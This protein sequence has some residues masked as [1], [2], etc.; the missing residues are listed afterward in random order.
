MS[1]S[2]IADGLCLYCE[3]NSRRAGDLYCCDGCQALSGLLEARPPHSSSHSDDPVLIRDFGRDQGESVLFECHVDPLACE[4][5][6]QGLVRLQNQIPEIRDLRWKRQNS[7]LSFEFAKGSEFPSRIFDLLQSMKLSPRWKK[8]NSPDGKEQNQLRSRWL[9]IGLTGAL[10]GNIMLLSFAIYAGLDGI[11]K[12]AFEWLQFVLFVPVFFWAAVPIYRTA[13]M[14]WRLR[15]LS[16]DLPLAVAFVSGSVLSTVSLLQGGDSLYYDSL[17]GFLFLILASRALLEGTLA[18]YLESPGLE[19][20]FDR[21]VFSVHRGQ[22][23]LRMSW[24]DLQVGDE[25]EL[26]SGDRIPVDG[27]LQ[28]PFAEIETAWMTGEKIPHLRLRGSEIEAGTRLL[29]KRALIEVTRLPQETQFAK[30]LQ[31]LSDRGE[32]IGTSLEGKIG[33]ALVVGCFLLIAL[34]FLVAPGLGF[35]ELFRRSIALLIVACPCAVSFAAP[36]ARAKANQIALK[37]GFWIRDPLVWWRLGRIRRLAFDKTGTLTGGLFVMAP[38]SPMIDAHWKRVILSLENISRHPIAE[39]LRREWGAMELFPVTDAREIPG[40]GVE[41]QI[42]GK[43]YR[44]KGEQDPERLLRVSLEQNGESVV[45]VLLQDEV[46]PSVEKTLGRFHKKFELFVISGDRKNRVQEFGRRYGFRSENLFSELSPEGKARA[47]DQ[48]Q[49]DLYFGDGTN[50]LPALKKAPVSVAVGAA[51]PEAQAAAD[52]LMVDAGFERCEELFEIAK[53]TRFIHRRN[54]TL[55]LVYNFAA[56]AAALFGVIHPLG[57]ALLMPLA[58]LGLLASTLRGT[59]ALRHL[60]KR[61]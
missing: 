34:L 18:S 14:S 1:T 16:V 33:S 29:S 5:C 60:G 46:V 47:L 53:E 6:L 32:K 11:L 30:L 49:P 26:E 15:Q 27:I 35:D 17:A 10:A 61:K 25:V 13:W 3:V 50:D 42:E 54:L 36:L 28:S 24:M 23:Q 45:Q 56:G 22:D 31:R 37:L 7:V 44:L 52:I 59:A 48:I 38:H 55:A 39:S 21:V 40:Q 9:R 8:A 12:T 51:S 58:S 43:S 41:G 2:S 57:A 19:R 20:F 4:A